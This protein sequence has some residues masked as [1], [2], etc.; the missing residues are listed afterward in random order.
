MSEIYDLTEND[1]RDLIKNIGLRAKLRKQIL[2]YKEKHERP[3]NIRNQIKRKHDASNE[4]I[5]KTLNSQT[6]MV[7]DSTSNCLPVLIKDLNFTQKLNLEDVLNRSTKG[8]LL[9]INKNEALLPKYK[10]LLVTIIVEFYLNK[11]VN[12]GLHDF[13]I[14]AGKIVSLFPKEDRNDYVIDCNES[15][16]RGKLCEKFYNSVSELKKNNLLSKKTTHTVTKNR[17]KYSCHYFYNFLVLFL[18]FV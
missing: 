14:V 4:E 7:D 15:K 6:K 3:I 1:L 8:Q 12:M 16:A 13:R 5:V 11:Q 10:N 2:S 18:Y 9:L 17:S